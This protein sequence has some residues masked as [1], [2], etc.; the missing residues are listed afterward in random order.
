MSNGDESGLETC[1]QKKKKAPSL[2]FV[3]WDSPSLFEVPCRRQSNLSLPKTSRH[4]MPR[5]ATRSLREPAQISGSGHGDH[6]GKGP[7]AFYTGKPE[8]KGNTGRSCSAGR[9]V[10]PHPETCLSAQ[11]PLPTHEHDRQIRH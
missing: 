4:A 5:S 7:S 9:A 6:V 3:R 10:H 1:I 11:R 2:L 8:A